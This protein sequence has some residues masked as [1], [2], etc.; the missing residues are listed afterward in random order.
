MVDRM[1]QNIGRVI[2][3][4]KDSGQY[5]N[6]IIVFMSDNGADGSVQ[7]RR[8]E[9][10]QVPPA[11]D[12]DNSLANIGRVGSFVSYGAG[13]AQAATSP[14]RLAKSSVAEGGI[15]TPAIFV[16]PG[17]RPGTINKALTHVMDITPTLL[18]FVGVSQVG[19]DTA[20]TI[21]PI[22]GHSLLPL[23]RARTNAVR[24]AGEDLNWEL[25][26][27]RAI[28]RGDWKAVYLKPD[29]TPG[30]V[31]S[32]WELFNL[33]ADPGETTDLAQKYPDRLAE[34]VKA[35]NAYAQEVGV[36]LPQ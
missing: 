14:S 13:W 29:T 11:R 33:K 36:A 26:F 7:E 35:W 15:H 24:S 34:L 10:P 2:K 3:S 18:D 32:R 30:S 6:T 22:R 28:R 31:S 20:R 27:G 17:I 16:G 8:A 19:V 1:D 12:Y 9:L 23:L 25:F 5:D 4:L 21:L